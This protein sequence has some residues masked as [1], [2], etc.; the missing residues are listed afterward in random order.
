MGITSISPSTIMIGSTGTQ[1]TINGAGVGTTPTVNL[2]SGVASTKQTATDTQI[3]LTVNVAYNSAIGNNDL[4]VTASGT[5]SNTANLVIDGPAY[6]LVALDQAGFCNGCSTTVQRL[7]R[8]QIMNFSG[9][10]NTMSTQEIGEAPSLTPSTCTPPGLT[11]FNA[12]G[13]SFPAFPV[14]GFFTDRWTMGRDGSTPVGCDIGVTL[15]IG[16]CV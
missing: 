5:K 3:M 11:S 10:S 7:V 14:A 2:P 4:S 9:T 6:M 1:L 15:I 13:S 16:R 8:Y 12:C